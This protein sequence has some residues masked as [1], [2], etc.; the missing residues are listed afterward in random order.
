M[1]VC[2]VVPSSELDGEGV[3]AAA[4]ELEPGTVTVSGCE[5]GVAAAELEPGTVTV[6][7]CGDGLDAAELE[8]GEPGTTEP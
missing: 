1:R 7:G 8:P 2:E 5:E 3:P 6:R 4:P